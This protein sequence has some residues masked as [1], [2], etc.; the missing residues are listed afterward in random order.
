MA[1]DVR[2]M[3]PDCGPDI[4]TC[5]PKTKGGVGGAAFGTIHD[6]AR[7]QGAKLRGRP[8]STPKPPLETQRTEG[9]NTITDRRLAYAGQCLT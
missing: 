1:P 6:A 7:H 8:L 2:V 4:A 3:D 9:P 5:R